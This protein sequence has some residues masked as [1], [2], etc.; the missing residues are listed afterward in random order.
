MTRKGAETKTGTKGTIAGVVVDQI[1]E[2]AGTADIAITTTVTD[3]KGNEKYSVTVN[4][5]DLV[6]GEK[7]T[8]VVKDEKTGKTQLERYYN[9]VKYLQIH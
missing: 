8:V 4:A 9:Y 7:L 2:A 1:K 5:G 6:A 3:A